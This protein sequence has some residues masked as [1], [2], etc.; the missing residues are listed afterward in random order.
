M[1]DLPIEQHLADRLKA[2]AQEQHRDLN[3]LLVDM[4]DQYALPRR[5]DWARIMAQMADEDTSSDWDQFSPDLAA[6]SREILDTEFADYLI[7][8]LE[9]SSNNG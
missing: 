2:L 6:R 9:E 8:R 7:R 5:K 3:D 4:L 1:V